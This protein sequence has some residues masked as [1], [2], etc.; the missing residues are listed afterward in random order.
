M[1]GEGGAITSVDTKAP[2]LTPGL[3][4]IWMAWRPD[5]DLTPLRIMKLS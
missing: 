4:H 5:Q 1:S 2:A 3:S